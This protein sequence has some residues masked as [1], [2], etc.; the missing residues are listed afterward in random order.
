MSA[1]AQGFEEPATS[2]HLHSDEAGD[3][4][5]RLV[6]ADD[7]AIVRK[8]LRE[9]VMAQPG[10]RIVG[11]ATDGEEACARARDLRPDVLLLD[12]SMPGMDGLEA[13]ER[14]THECPEIRIVVLT[15][16]EE[17]SYVER[18]ART[19]AAGYVLKRSAAAVL[20]SAI[21]VVAAGGSYVDPALTG[22][23]RSAAPDPPPRQGA[24]DDREVLT[25][26]EAALLL[27]VARGQSNGEIAATLGV[28]VASVERDRGR[29][30]TKLG[31]RSRAALMRHA[32]ERG[33]LTA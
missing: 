22:E 33:W 30:M 4:T 16:H 14:I 11:E 31:L 19:G 17:R 32:T 25:G 2:P 20:A 26:W 7:S 13:A 1:H 12:V 23:P 10:L 3:A 21:R 15:M 8:G 27:L 6:I 28:S 5:I 29:S 24:R 18:M 9:H